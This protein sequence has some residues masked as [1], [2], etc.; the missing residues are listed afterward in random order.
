M[1]LETDV[2]VRFAIIGLVNE[3]YLK[4]SSGWGDLVDLDQLA[5]NKM[6]ERVAE[7]PES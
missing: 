7:P 3:N 4:T 1:D 2:P 5:F 6:A